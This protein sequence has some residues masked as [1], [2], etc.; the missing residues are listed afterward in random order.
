[1][2]GLCRKSLSFYCGIYRLE[3]CLLIFYLFNAFQKK[4]R[5]L[6]FLENMSSLEKLLLQKIV[7]SAKQCHLKNVWPLKK[8]GQM[9]SLDKETYIFLF[10]DKKCFNFWQFSL[11]F[12][13]SNYSRTALFKDPPKTLSDVTFKTENSQ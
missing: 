4:S 6:N 13:F 2:G 11:P 3:T 10:L 8:E 7:K 12:D 9:C 1:M 5:I